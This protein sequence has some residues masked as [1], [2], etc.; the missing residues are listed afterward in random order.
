MVGMASPGLGRGLRTGW[1]SARFRHRTGSSGGRG[2]GHQGALPPVPLGASSRSSGGAA[3]SPSMAGR[4][5]S[6]SV[7]GRSPRA[8]TG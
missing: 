5:G 2:C 1:V 6:R 3:S 8:G 4:R 7:S